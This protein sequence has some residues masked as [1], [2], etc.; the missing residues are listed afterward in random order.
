MTQ[1]IDDRIHEVT[2]LLHQAAETHHV[3]FAISDGDDP[4]WASWYADWLLNLSALPR[5]LGTRPV[6]SELTWMLVGLDKEFTREQPSG[7]WEEFYA[8]KLV[9]HFENASR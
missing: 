5:I 9:Q 8:Q 1:T 4:D 7:A 3:V 6:R 2:Q